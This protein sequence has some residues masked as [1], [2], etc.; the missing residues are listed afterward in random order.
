M[1]KKITGDVVLAQP[2]GLDSNIYLAGDTV[3]DAGSGL[4]FT[5]LQDL[6]KIMKKTLEDWKWVV[7]THC[8][9]DHCGG[10]GYFFNAQIA[11]HELDSPVLE[12]GDTQKS[13]ADA[14]D[15]T[16]KPKKVARRL[17][18]GDI[19]QAGP[20]TLEVLHTPGHTPGSICLYEKKQKILFSG[21]T[22][23][24]DGVGRIDLPGGNEEQLADSIE[25]I[26]SLDVQKLLPGHG[27][28][29]LEGAKK[30]MEK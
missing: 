6:L 24:A 16:L 25:R 22:L 9:F 23:F 21:D 14:F 18:D 2:S 1:I 20:L 28:P 5:R 13:V 19:I 29:V 26:L 7:N 12:A 10:D 17:K 27:T 3:I 11:M 4:N 8:H 30:Q 15:A